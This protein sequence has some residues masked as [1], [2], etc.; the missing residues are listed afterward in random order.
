MTTQSAHKTENNSRLACRAMTSFV[1]VAMLTAG[2]ASRPKVKI[3]DAFDEQAIAAEITSSGPIA[4]ESENEAAGQT[5]I[6]KSAMAAQ[7]S[8]PRSLS[9]C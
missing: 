4:I 7:A 3:S 5:M 8:V 6:R 2:C 9:F 1:V